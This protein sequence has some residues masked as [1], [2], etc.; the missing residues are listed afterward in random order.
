LQG[1]LRIM[2]RVRLT[3]QAA[4]AWIRTCFHTFVFAAYPV[5]L[6]M[7]AN[8]GI[9]PLDG[10][11]LARSV[12]VSI[13]TTL[14]LLLALRLVVPDLR[15]RAAWLSF[16]CIAFMLYPAVGGTSMSPVLASVY[17]ASSVAFAT[18]VVRP[19]KVRTRRSAALNAGAVLVLGVNLYTFAPAFWH[20]AAW[21][22]AA[23]AL[24][25]SV[26]AS[27]GTVAP[28]PRG[29]IYYI[30]LD[31]FGRP[32]VL[33]NRY[34]LDLAPFVAAL[35]SR[36]FDVP[37]RSQS[38]YSQ[39]FLSLASSLN[40][41]YLDPVAAAMADSN[42]RRVLHYL[43]QN[44]ALMKLAR[45]AGYRVIAIG[46]D[47]EATDRIAEADV[48]HCEQF[49]LHEVEATAVSLTP[50]RAL[51]I[52]RWTY[53]AHRRKVEASFQHL[54]DSSRL[55]G[56]KLVFAHILAPHPPFV[57][58]ADGG[59]VSNDTRIFSLADGDQP[60]GSPEE[61]AAGYRDQ[62]AFVARRMLDVIDA[63]LARPGPPP[64]IVVHG[65]HGPGA[66][67]EWSDFRGDSGHESMGILAAYLF[68]ANRRP[69]LPPTITPVNALRLVA[70]RQ[71]G[72]VL[73][74]LP[75]VSYAS[76]WKQPFQFEPI[77]PAVPTTAK[78]NPN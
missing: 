25:A 22:P 33:E 44:N 7:G 77:S 76:T 23:D 16:V 31:A 51:P 63:I 15:A 45:R 24:I 61:Y 46:S 73:P 13:V 8:A 32:D 75:D 74:M 69:V 30:V 55:A 64:A 62:A 9:V 70:N 10:R 29:D 27:P 34:G 67:R 21:R 20:R 53:G 3:I 14:L 6:V 41:S 78:R 72:T 52:E 39:T 38:N 17:T 28:E 36:G 47:Y 56:P 43:I 60:A 11:V 68:P 54:I 58:G 66:R 26:A 35:R 5:L 57:F 2:T 1:I 48:C 49:G 71:L 42:D 65:D 50:L 18:A 59:T 4:A 37:E 19:W 12:A 40:L